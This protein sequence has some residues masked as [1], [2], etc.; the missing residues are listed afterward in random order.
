MN[1]LIVFAPALLSATWVVVGFAYAWRGSKPAVA[2]F[3]GGDWGLIPPK[4]WRRR[5]IWSQAL[6]IAADSILMAVASLAYSNAYLTSTEKTLLFS[7]MLYVFLDSAA[8]EQCGIRGKFRI[9]RLRFALCHAGGSVW[10]L[11]VSV[12]WSAFLLAGGQA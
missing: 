5:F 2:G 8:A 3:A 6:L 11:V 9:R 4:G 1:G 10:C 7:L 12:G